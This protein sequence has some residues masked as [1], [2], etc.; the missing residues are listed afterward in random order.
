MF[1][2]RK[3]SAETVRKF[4]DGQDDLDFTYAPVGATADVPPADYRLNHTRKRI[5]AGR[6]AFARARAALRR[7]DQFRIG[8]AEIRPADAV[9]RPGAV[10]AIV[11]RRLGL[12]WLNACRVVYVVDEDGEA[13]A[14][15]GVAFGTLPG[16]VGSG[17][18]RFQ[19]EWDGA[20][21]EVWYDV[22][23][24]SQPHLWLTRLGYP[25][26]RRSQKLF[27]RQ[28]AAAMVEALARE[29]TVPPP[30]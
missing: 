18:E 28:S 3:P 9:V 27:G 5:G 16:H 30:G 29:A 19:V 10:V 26:M 12:W 15:F 1:T 25:Y 8:W 2:F 6:E 21:D 22:S 24:F 11:A 7:W 14:R 17:E 23:S 4:L 13:A 20:T